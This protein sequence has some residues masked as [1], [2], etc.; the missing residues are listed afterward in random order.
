MTGP[1]SGFIAPNYDSGF[2][3]IPTTLTAL[4]TKTLGLTVGN[5]SNSTTTSIEV[6]ITNTAGDK[7]WDKILVPPGEPWTVPFHLFKVVGIKWMVNV[8]GV[9]AAIQGYE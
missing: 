7:V 5:F 8:T 1:Y 9:K 4:T 6:T 2:I 3:T